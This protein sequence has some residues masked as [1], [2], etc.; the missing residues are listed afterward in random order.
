MN[1]RSF[2][3]LVTWNVI[4]T[5][6]LLIA[7]AFV[8]VSAQAANDPPVKVY[9]AT[10]AHG[11]GIAG[12][13]VNDKTISSTTFADILTI[14]V[15]FTGQT[16]NHYCV[17]IGSANLINPALGSTGHRY[18]FGVGY[19]ANT[20]ASYSFSNMQ[21]EFS[22][23]AGVDD[24]SYL[25]VTS[26]RV[27]GALTP[28]AHTLRFQGRKLAAGSPNLTV[29]NASAT[30]ICFKKYQTM[31]GASEPEGPAPDNFANDQ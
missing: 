8:A 9:T 7:L 17:M 4:L 18:E 6:L 14:S 26:N 15:N 10:Y 21:V 16:H 30:A 28:A 25:P 11:N 3:L 20:A 5:V 1:T 27:F 12:T 19:D 24:L 2:R 23:N 13:A 31:L 29:D 22:D